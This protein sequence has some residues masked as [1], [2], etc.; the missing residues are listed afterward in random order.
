MNSSLHS[1]RWKNTLIDFSIPKVMGIVN[2][3]PDSFYKSSRVD[4]T[5]LSEYISQMINEG[6]DILDIGGCSSRPGAEIIPVEEE[7]NRIL[8]AI[9][10]CCNHYPNTPLSIDTMHSEVVNAVSQFPICFINDIS[11]GTFDFNM[12]PTVAK[13]EFAFGIM[14]MKG[15]PNS[16]QDNPQYD[17]D[18]V[19]EIMQF[20]Q[21]QIQSAID[22]GIHDILIDPGFGFGKS[23]KDNYTILSRLKEF[24]LL[25]HPLLIGVSRKSMIKSL[26]NISADEALNG[27]SILHS[28]ALERGANIIRTHDVKAAKE[29]VSLFQAIQQPDLL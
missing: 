4:Q 3:T 19:A 14:H 21:V 17:S 22:E 27:G 25:N 13:H 28:F 6:A 18:V 24:S 2:C 10:Y 8:P 29:A 16:M 26:L 12:I 15:L 20:L 23:L 9:E 11:G 7:I 5:I 1:I